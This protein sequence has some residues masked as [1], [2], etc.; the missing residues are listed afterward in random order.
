V[1]YLPVLLVLSGILRAYI[2]SAWTLTYLRLTGRT[3]VPPAAEAPQ[4][5]PAL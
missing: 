1:L 4:V 2:G 5:E 3:P